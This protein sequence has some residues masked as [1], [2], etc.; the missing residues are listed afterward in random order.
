MKG[1]RRRDVIARGVAG[2]IAAALGALGP[3]DVASAKPLRGR[4]RKHAKKSHPRPRPL[5]SQTDVV[6]VGAGLA[7]LTAARAV[8]AAGR[9]VLV[10]EA[11]DRVGGRNLDLSIGSGKV[12][13]MGGQWT[14]PGQDQVQALAK[15]LG[16]GL[17]P[18]F[19]AG[20]NVYY[21]SGQAQSYS[22]DIPP[23]SPA[24]LAEL[25]L[26]ITLLNQMASGVSAEQ[27]WTAPQAT[28]Y[29]IQ[30]IQ[31]WN[32]GQNHTDEARALI[33]L[34][35]RGVYG[36]DSGQISFLDLLA[37]IT[38]VGGDINTL[39][40]SAQS[41]R[42]DGGPQRLSEGLASKLSGLVRT[43]SAVVG[44]ERAAISTVHT[45]AVSHRARHVILTPPKPVIARIIFR[46]ELP[47]V[48]AQ[49]LQRQPMGATIKI[50]AVYDSPFWRA[51]GLS[52]AVVST[53][54]PVEIV[55]D[56][57]PADGTPGV[58]VGFM[59]G[60]QGRALF[61]ASP[62]DRRAA[63]LAS[64]VRYFGARAGQPRQYFDMVW[65]HE[66][67]TLGAYGDFNP[68]GVITS[69]GPATDA[70]V[71]GL[72]F[73]GDGYAPEWPGYMEGAIRSGQRA[74]KEALAGL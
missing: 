14:G 72:H 5:V 13:E 70:P 55:Y 66:P 1:L 65:A 49:F 32:D 45:A 23:A 27:P 57:S 39:I 36:E 28:S 25:E 16:V 40:G 64:L 46:P 30:T 51:D 43:G 8:Q 22:G 74:A 2:A 48:Y 12:V 44:I 73:A 52:G 18:T 9:S 62:A 69:F 35:I 47:P 54:G 56:N 21:R 42:F 3:G 60:N 26:S 10:L 53:D 19:S 31:A 6:V 50:Q 71:D 63:A 59:E 24:A 34:A 61:G 67:Y 17:F 15:E 58:L 37:Q 20:N 29:D 68:P 38:G 7:G 11:R 4:R 41:I 33:D